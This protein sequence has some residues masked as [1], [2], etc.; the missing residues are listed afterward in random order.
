MEDESAA[1][2]QEHQ[3]HGLLD[4]LLEGDLSLQNALTTCFPLDPD[5]IVFPY[6]EAANLGG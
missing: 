2:S 4:T 3:R 1:Y 6:W 5:A